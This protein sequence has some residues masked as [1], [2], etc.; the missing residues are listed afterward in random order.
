MIEGRKTMLKK[1]LSVTVVLAMC[2]VLISGLPLASVAKAAITGFEGKGT[3][4]NPYL[5]TSAEDLK[6]LADT[7][8]DGEDCSGI[9]FKLTTDIDLNKAGICGENIGGKEMLWTPIGV[10]VTTGRYD[11]TR[12]HGAFDGDNHEIS[13]LYINAPSGSLYAYYSGL[14]GC[15]G[16]NGVVKNLSVNGYLKG[17]G[18]VSSIAGMSYGRI[19]NC[20][21][22][23]TV[24]ARSYI[25]GIVGYNYTYADNGE[26]KTGIVVNCYNS[27]NVHG[28]KVLGN[29]NYVGGIV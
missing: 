10:S 12:F 15:I 17:H 23:A 2:L 8:N 3:E 7:V 21:S 22:S 9:Y 13:G 4:R 24:T 29:G 28:T 18:V 6:R 14:F 11:G 19:D 16:E 1:L 27:D 20:Y 5:I 25:G 26:T